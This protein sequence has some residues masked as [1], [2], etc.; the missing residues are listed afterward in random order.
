[1]ES[2]G[3]YAVSGFFHSSSWR[4]SYII[5]IAVILFFIAS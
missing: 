2:F 1:M 4:D 3:K 5:D